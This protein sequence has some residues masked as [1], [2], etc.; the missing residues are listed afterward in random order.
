MKARFATEEK[1]AAYV[2]SILGTGFYSN[3]MKCAEL[4]GKSP[5]E[6]VRLIEECPTSEMTSLFRE[7]I[8]F[9]CLHYVVMP[10]LK[11]RIKEGKINVASV[12]CATGEEAYSIL[13]QNWSDR[14][15]FSF[16]GYDVNPRNINRAREGIIQSVSVK[17]IEQALETSDFRDSFDLIGEPRA[18]YISIAM[19]SK[20]KESI[21]FQLH[22]IIYSPLQKKQDLIVMCH[23]L[24]HY[25][26]EARVQILNNVTRSLNP[27]GWLVCE[28][29]ACWDD[30]TTYLKFMKNLTRFG[31]RKKKTLVPWWGNPKN[32][33]TWNSKVYQKTA[34]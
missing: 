5:D 29:I 23:V 6:K 26:Q 25:T 32:N 14:E 27:K 12:G 34:V 24:P 30:Y 4:A 8:V 17:D 20:T 16:Q 9:R 1:A 31:L 19:K 21:D 3:S 11:N 33:M 18:D 22:N 28:G 10:E 7:D 15:R 2:D 13:M